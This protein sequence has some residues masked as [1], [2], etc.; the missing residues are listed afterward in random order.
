[1]AVRKCGRGGG[2]RSEIL[3]YWQAGKLPFHC[4]MDAG[5][6]MRL[7]GQ[8]Q[9][10]L[11]SR[12]SSLYEHNIC[13]LSPCSPPPP[14]PYTYKPHGSDW[15]LP[16]WKCTLWVCVTAEEPW[17]KEFE[18]FV[19]SS[20][21]IWPSMQRSHQLCHSVLCNILERQ[22]QVVPLLRRYEEMLEIYGDLSL[23][24]NQLATN[25]CVLCPNS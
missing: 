16:E 25:S 6:G 20:R 7:P 10:A 14:N 21:Q 4:F 18:S 9:R 11:F 24:I 8:K 13:L 2:G 3:P 5:R 15:S 19:M 17:D 23:N 12:H 22:R 1:M